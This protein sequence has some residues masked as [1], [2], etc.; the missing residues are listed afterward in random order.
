MNHEKPEFTKKFIMNLSSRLPEGA[1]LWVGG[2]NL[3]S[4]IYPEPLIK[5]IPSLQ[6]LDMELS[7]MSSSK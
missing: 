1:K 6:N 7:K 4:S 3:D 2:G 5:I